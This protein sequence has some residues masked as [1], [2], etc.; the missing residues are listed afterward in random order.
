MSQIQNKHE[1]ESKL[2]LICMIGIVAATVLLVAVAIFAQHQQL[3][4]EAAA[5]TSLQSS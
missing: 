4:I 5:S 2:W 1:K 3:S